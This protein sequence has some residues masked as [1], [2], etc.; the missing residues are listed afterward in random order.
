M[1]NVRLREALLVLTRTTASVRLM[2]YRHRKANERLADQQKR[3]AEGRI[4]APAMRFVW[5]K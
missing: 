5:P 3:K 2:T 4:S 1:N